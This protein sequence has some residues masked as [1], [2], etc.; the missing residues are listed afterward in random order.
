VPQPNTFVSQMWDD[1]KDSN[2]YPV[3]EVTGFRYDP[4]K[5]ANVVGFLGANYFGAPNVW[6]NGGIVGQSPTVIT[7][8][9]G[10]CA[11]CFAPAFVPQGGVGFG[12]AARFPQGFVG[13]SLSGGFLGNFH[14]FAGGTRAGGTLNR[15]DLFRGGTLSGGFITSSFAGGTRAGGTLNRLDLFAGGSAPGGKL[16][17]VDVFAGGTVSGG[18]LGA[19]DVFTGGCKS[20]GVLVLPA[21]P[22][23]VFTGGCKSG[24]VLILPA[25][26]AAVFTGGC[27][28]GGVVV[29]PAPSATVFTGG[30]NCGGTCIDS[31]P[32]VPVFRGGTKS[33]GVLVLPAPPATVFT[34]GCKSNGNFT[35]D[36]MSYPVTAT[37]WPDEA[38]VIAGTASIN[39]VSTVLPY[40]EYTEFPSPGIGDWLSWKFFLAAG[41]YTLYVIGITG[42][43]YGQVQVL[44]DSVIQSGVLD[45]YANPGSVNVILSLGITVST[46]GVHQLDLKVSGKNASSSNYYFLPTKIWV[47]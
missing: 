42:S 2:V 9:N 30:T 22:A 38:T 17:R 19:I 14:S 32:F 29:L 43:P 27:K 21:P 10:S 12:G 16:A 8:P 5:G 40:T 23:T 6:K 1:P 13:G 39:I 11:A 34:G 44:I 31:S 15:L 37:M 36:Q 35:G 47:K 24:G 3:G 46:S 28:S 33:G 18:D 41:S 26:P 4:Q 45:W 25:P 7:N 20:G